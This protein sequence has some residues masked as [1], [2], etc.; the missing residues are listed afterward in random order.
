EAMKHGAFDF[1][2]KPLDLAE[3]ESRVRLAREARRLM[4]VPVVISATDDD[5]ESEGD[6]L[7]GR[8]PAMA[9]VFKG[10]GRAA[11]R[12]MSVL[13]VGEQGTGKALVA[14][15]IYQNSGRSTASF[16]VVSCSDFDSPQL[17]VELFGAESPYAMVGRIEQCSSGTLLLEE[18]GE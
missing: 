6:P 7:I 14:R 4:R 18:I 11:A 3:L 8:S 16:R 2:S 10:I 17:E 12:D 13:L 5:P 15:A 9:D 1:L